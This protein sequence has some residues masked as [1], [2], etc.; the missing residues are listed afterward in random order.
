MTPST[1]ETAEVVDLGIRGRSVRRL[2]NSS[3]VETARR[4][5]A[6]DFDVLQFLCECGTPGCNLLVTLAICEFDPASPPGAVVAF[7]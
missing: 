4:Y 1:H 2:A 5:G 7:H 3:M 6:G